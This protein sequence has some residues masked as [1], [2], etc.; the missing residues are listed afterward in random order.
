M[1]L[2]WPCVWWK[3]CARNRAT[4]KRR[5]L[6]GTD[7]KQSFRNFF[8]TDMEPEPGRHYLIFR[9][10]PEQGRLLVSFFR[11]RQNKSGLSTV[12]TEVTLEQIIQNPDWCEFS[13]QLPPCGPPDRPA[14]R[15]LRTSGGNSRWS[16]LLVFLVRAQGV[17]PALERLGQALPHRKHA[18]CPQ[19]QAQAGRY[20]LQFRG[21][22]E[23]RRPPA[24]AHSS[25][26]CRQCPKRRAGQPGGR[27][28]HLSRSDAALGLLPA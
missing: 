11:G 24:F 12:H 25:G 16:H 1:W 10:A 3:N 14:S 23:T 8:S 28:D 15:L 17:L 13:P 22:S 26:Q 6:P 27:A 21:A 20:G 5:L 2:R 18:L 19:A 7:W 4:R 9:F